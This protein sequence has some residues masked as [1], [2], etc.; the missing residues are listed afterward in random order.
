MSHMR[1]DTLI[2]NHKKG[3][4]KGNLLS[5]AEQKKRKAFSVCW[6]DLLNV[7]KL[8]DQRL[9]EVLVA[10]SIINHC[11]STACG[12]CLMV[13]LGSNTFYP[14]SSRVTWLW[15]TIA[16]CS[17]MTGVFLCNSI[18][19]ELS[20]PCLM[21]PELSS[22]IYLNHYSWLFDL[23]FILNTNL[24]T[25]TWKIQHIKKNVS[26]QWSPCSKLPCISG[27]LESVLYR[28]KEEEE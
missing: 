28:E 6:T 8:N 19:N 9:V 4:S 16:F 24:A 20:I 12:K 26:A 5:S 14:K 18:Q 27:E 11:A 2:L 23:L 1:T 7:D 21:Q 15:F 22:A 10:L 3:T 17:N 25:R 13:A